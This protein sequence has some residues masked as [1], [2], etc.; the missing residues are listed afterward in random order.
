VQY[1]AIPS[2]DDFDKLKIYSYSFDA[3]SH[4]GRISVMH[5]MESDL[6]ANN[7]DELTAD[8]IVKGTDEFAQNAAQH[9][10]GWM[11]GNLVEVNMWI[12]LHHVFTAVPSHGGSYDYR[13][14]KSDIAEILELRSMMKEKYSGLDKSKIRKNADM[15]KLWD[16]RGRG[17][18]IAALR[19]NLVLA[20]QPGSPDDNQYLDMMLFKALPNYSGSIN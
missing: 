20:N 19:F 14:M 5:R 17:G 8:S 4:E 10:Y 11:P 6:L 7:I 16:M 18:A 15:A 2:I 3:S 1:D 13:K 9:A 12:A